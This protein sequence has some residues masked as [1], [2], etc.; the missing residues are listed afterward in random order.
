MVNDS[1]DA[2]CNSVMKLKVFSNCEYLCLFA[3]K[4]IQPGQEILYSYGEKENLW[5]RLKVKRRHLH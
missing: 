2:T 1:P 5:W 4:D 3:I